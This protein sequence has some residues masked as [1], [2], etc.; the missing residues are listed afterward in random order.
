M[1]FPSIM[2]DMRWLVSPVLLAILLIGCARPPGACPPL[3]IADLSGAAA[4]ATDDRFP[5]RLPLDAFVDET[6]SSYTDFCASGGTESARQYHAAEDYFLPAGTPVYAMAGGKISF[7]GPMGGYGWLII[8]DHPQAN[9]YSL[10]GHLSPS[11][12]R[13][14]SGTVQKG[15]LIAYL[16]DADENGGSSERPLRPHLHL[17]VRS[18]QRSDYAG[19]GDWRWQAGWIK[20]CPRDLGWLQPSA[21]ITSQKIPVGGFPEP[22]AG[23]FAI[24][25]IELL[26]ASPYVISGVYLLIFAIR[27]N[28]PFLL[29][30][31]GIVLIAAGWYF[32][33]KGMIVSYAI[34]TM[35]ALL[36]AVGIH[37]LVRRSIKR[38]CIGS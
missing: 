10:Y 27:R 29:I 36:L 2:H 16:G 8:V 13:K 12:W 25:W 1:N 37:R 30:L 26:L 14:K 38:P 5:F 23:F 32:S 34:Y 35:A 28:K 24:W 17:G 4:Y 6:D 22:A 18:G 20:S 33:I 21:I 31:A 3:P 19:K 9:L 11:R 15:E 7:S